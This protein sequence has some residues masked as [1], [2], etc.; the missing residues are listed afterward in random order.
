MNTADLCAQATDKRG[1]LAQFQDTGTLIRMLQ[2]T[3]SESDRCRKFCRSTFCGGTRTIKF[4]A[5]MPAQAMRRRVPIIGLLDGSGQKICRAHPK[6]RYWRQD[7]PE[8][9]IG[10]C[11][12]RRAF[13]EGVR[14]N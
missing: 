10:L 7:R 14:L 11:C 12:A 4:A 5:Y 8:S 6:N 3:R 9:K 13:R 1:R 2:E